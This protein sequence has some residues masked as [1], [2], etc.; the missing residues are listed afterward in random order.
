[1]NIKKSVL[2]AIGDTPIIEIERYR[3]F[4]KNPNTLYTKV[5]FFNPGGSVK[6]RVGLRLMQSAYEHGYIDHHSTIIEPTSGNTGIGLA[7]A[8]AVFGNPLILTMPESMSIERQKLLK[9][10]GAKII[11][12]PASEGMQG[13]VEKAKQLHQ[14]IKNSYIPNQFHNVENYHIHELT[15]A[16]EILD[17][18]EGNIDYFVAGVGTGGTLT[19]IGHILKMHD[20]NIK[21]IAVEP[22]HSPLLSKGKSGH[23]GL[24]GIGANFIPD[25]LDQEIIDD[26]ITVSEEDAY[27]ASRHLALKE[28]LL[29]GISAGAALHAACQIQDQGKNIL[30]LLPDTGE[31]YLSTD[32]FQ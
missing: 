19:G 29:V 23:H 28:G 20:P 6:D 2:E 18:L 21:I 15:T 25:I 9:A 22:T 13:S 16:L 8:C 24:Q 30:V 11:L 5:E 17:D 26:I 4:V 27:Q 12:T 3:Q 10:Y 7:I 14:E 1:M 31:R 32:L